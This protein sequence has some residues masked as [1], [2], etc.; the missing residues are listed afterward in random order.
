MFSRYR[1]DCYF[2]N[3]CFLTFNLTFAATPAILPAD[4][5]VSATLTMVVLVLVNLTLQM[6]LWP[7]KATP[8]ARLMLVSTS[9]LGDVCHRSSRLV[10]C[11]SLDV[12]TLE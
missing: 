8:L 2:F 7:W 4:S 1:D 12:R 3:A 6:R 10:F 5:P 11:V 9:I